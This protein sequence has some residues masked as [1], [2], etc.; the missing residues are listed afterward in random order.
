VE[1]SLNNK[2]V[3]DASRGL[4]VRV[5]SLVNQKVMDLNPSKGHC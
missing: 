1:D 2:D 5:F 4:G 3:R